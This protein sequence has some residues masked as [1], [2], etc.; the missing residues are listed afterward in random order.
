LAINLSKSKRSSN[1]LIEDQK[2]LRIELNAKLDRSLLH[3]RNVKYLKPLSLKYEEYPLYLERSIRLE[4]GLSLNRKWYSTKNE[5]S[6][7]S[8]K[9]KGVLKNAKE[10]FT[11]KRGRYTISFSSSYEPNRDLSSMDIDALYL[12]DI[13]MKEID[14]AI[15]D[16]N[17]GEEGE[18]E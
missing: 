8:R 17:I 1:L 15:T 6:S 3:I 13:Y 4:K 11:N 5:G 16:T 18:D 12:E 2:L 10:W 9:K 7:K 14:H